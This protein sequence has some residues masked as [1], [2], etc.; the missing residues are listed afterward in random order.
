MRLIFDGQPIEFEA[1]DSALVALL[2]SGQRPMPGGCLCLGGDCPHC[3]ATVDGVSYVRTC[4]V[5]AQPGMII[6]RHPET[7]DPPLRLDT[8]AQ[9]AEVVAH[10]RY[11]DMA[12]IG[13]GQ[14][15][16]AA[17]DEA[18]QAGKQVKPWKRLKA[19]K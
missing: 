3:L 13:Q 10:H 6:E 15:G 18:R 5:V 8:A 2:R 7:G 16:K 14:A 4:Q 9:A 11:C 17:A 1:G 12:V 19:R